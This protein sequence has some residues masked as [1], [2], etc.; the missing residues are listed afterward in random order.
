M[1]IHNYTVEANK[2]KIKGQLPFEQL[3]GFCKTF[4]KTTKNI[5]F[6]LTF[7]MN[8]LQ[9]IIFTTIVTDINVTIKVYIYMSL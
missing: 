7:K 2:G 6:H 9:N 1:L 3:F 8:D 5:G 4:K